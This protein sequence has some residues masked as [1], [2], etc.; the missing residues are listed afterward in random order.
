LIFAQ[1]PDKIENPLLA[2]QASPGMGKSTFIDALASL[3]FE[4]IVEMSPAA[5][6]ADFHRA[7]SESIRVTID[8]NGLQPVTDRDLEYPVAAAGLRILHS[9]V[10]F[11]VKFLFGCHFHSCSSLRTVCLES[12]MFQ[13]CA[14]GIFALLAV[15]CNFSLMR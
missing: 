1:S 5:S 6:T 11:V 7:M 2:T 15:K 3:S 9:Y 10:H 12:V 8:Y 14:T 4:Q 13:F